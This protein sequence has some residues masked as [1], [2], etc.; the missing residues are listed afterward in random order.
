MQKL[1]NAVPTAGEGDRILRMISALVT[2]GVDA[3]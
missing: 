2:A 3:G 1:V